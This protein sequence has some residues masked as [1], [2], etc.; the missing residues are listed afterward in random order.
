MK[1]KIQKLDPKAVYH[2]QGLNKDGSE[3]IDHTVISK[4]LRRGQM[5]AEAKLKQM[6]QAEIAKIK[7]DNETNLDAFD[8]EVPAEPSPIHSW[9]IVRPVGKKE[10]ENELKRQQKQKQKV[11]GAQVPGDRKSATTDGA[12]RLEDDKTKSTTSARENAAEGADE[13]ED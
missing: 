10:I 8:F 6:V 13:E 5:S 1:T 7:E 4:P 12:K 3:K 11:T 2:A 9:V